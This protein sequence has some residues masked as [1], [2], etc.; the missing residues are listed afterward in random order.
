MA[1]NKDKIKAWL[2]YNVMYYV[3][4]GGLFLVVWLLLKL[5]KVIGFM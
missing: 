4:I 3:F 5:L 2:Q 1:I